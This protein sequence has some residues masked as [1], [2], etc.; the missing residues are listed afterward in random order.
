[1]VLSLVLAGV[2]YQFC[3]GT[4]ITTAL[5]SGMEEAIG[6]TVDLENA[7][8]DL[9]AGCMTLT[10]IASADPNALD[11][12]IFRAEK[13]EVDISGANLLRKRLQLDRVV[14]TGATSGEKRKIPGRRTGASAWLRPK[15]G[16]IRS[17]A[18]LP[19]NQLSPIR[20]RSKS[21]SAE[22]PK[23]RATTA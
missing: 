6:A 18:L 13:I 4:I 23:L 14:I 17:A 9:K 11:T 5:R 19:R 12:D 16:W 2:M 3:S 20:K 10:G 15:N 8:I 7:E 21:A 22:L 1:M